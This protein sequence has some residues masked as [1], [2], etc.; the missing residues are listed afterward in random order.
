M[1][2]KEKLTEKCVC[3]C[4]AV[5]T[6]LKLKRHATT[7]KHLK[8]LESLTPIE[9]LTTTQ[10]EFTTTQE[11]LTTTQEEL[12]TTQEELTTTQE[13]FTTT[14]EELITTQEFTNTE[15]NINVIPQRKKKPINLI[16]ITFEE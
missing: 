2:H 3:E 15:L 13:E 14:Q 4:G 9:E 12:T 6:K 16:K 7:K 5:I 10:E 8:Y 1:K 11:E